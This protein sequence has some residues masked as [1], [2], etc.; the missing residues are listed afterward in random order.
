MIITFSPQVKLPESDYL[1]IKVIGDILYV[2]YEDKEEEYDFTLMGEGE[3]QSV[4]STNISIEPLY[5][6]KRT[7]TELC[8][9]LYRPTTY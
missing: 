1:F 8:I 4:E 2:K 9:T 7:D 3:L 6:A 5:E